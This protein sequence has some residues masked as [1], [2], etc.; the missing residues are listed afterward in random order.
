MAATLALEARGSRKQMRLSQAQVSEA[1]GVSRTRYAEME[2]GDGAHAPLE[3]WV[4]LGFA[5]GRPLAVS[6]SRDSST[7]GSAADPRDAGHLAAQELVLGLAREHGRAA[8]V[9]LPTRPYDPVYSADVVL[10]DDRLRTLLLIEIIN[11]AGDLGATARSTDRKAAELERFAILAGGDDGPYRVAQGWLLV[12]TAA[13]RQLVAKYPQF[14]RTRHPGSSTAWARAISDGSEPPAE[15]A[16]AWI[17][18]RSGRIFP[19]H[20]KA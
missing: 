11:R 12:D 6:F 15:S 19:M 7:D 13:N 8:N 9:E 2:R 20:W 5:L 3:L 18:P 17:D 10:C 16:I 14:L 1:I 4:K